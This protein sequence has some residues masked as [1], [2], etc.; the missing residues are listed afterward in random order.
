MTLYERAEWHN[1]GCCRTT[2]HGMVLFNGTQLT[3]VKHCKLPSEQLE[4]AVRQIS[5]SCSV[6]FVNPVVRTLLSGKQSDLWF[7]G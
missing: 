7:D 2:A 6:T 3:D 1:T 5:S 4:N